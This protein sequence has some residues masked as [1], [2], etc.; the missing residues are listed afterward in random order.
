MPDTG[1][2]TR[3]ARGSSGRRRRDDRRERHPQ[4][5]PAEGICEAALHLV[6]KERQRLRA[7]CANGVSDG[8]A[9][10]E[11]PGGS[12]CVDRMSPLLHD[13]DADVVEALTLEQGA[14]RAR[15][16]EAERR[17]VETRRVIGKNSRMVSCVMRTKNVTRSW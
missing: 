6:S 3:G 5:R 7:T 12:P 16:V 14:Q 15:I 1:R 8:I 2:R 9:L 4:V 10:Q 17:L 13:F 11:G